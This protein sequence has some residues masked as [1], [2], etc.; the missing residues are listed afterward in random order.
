M[1]KTLLLIVLVISLTSFG[2][3]PTSSGLSGNNATSTSEGY[4]F[5]FSTASCFESSVI[6]NAGSSKKYGMTYNT[7]SSY[8]EFTFD[9]KI[10]ENYE[11]LWN[12]FPTRDCTPTT[13]DL[14][15]S[16]AK[17]KA[18][19]KATVYISNFHIGVV[20]NQDGQAALADELFSENLVELEPNKW[21]IVEFSI[22]TKGWHNGGFNDVDLDKTIGLFFTTRNN[23][24]SP[25]GSVAI[26]WITV[27]DGDGN[28]IYDDR[29]TTDTTL[30]CK[31][32]IYDTVKVMLSVTDTLRIKLNVVTGIDHKNTDSE[33]KVY[34]N[35]AVDKI[36]VAISNASVLNN[37]KLELRN[38]TSALLWEQTINTSDYSIDVS[39]LEGKGLYFLNIFKDNGQLIDVRK[40]ILE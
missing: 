28:Q 33:I 1:K 29:K 14:S 40:I 34:P 30:K 12:R 24:F 8:A 3:I 5:N 38:T 35:P 16:F 31:E 6:F 9:E 25:T 36:N 7:D 19:V 32:T 18:K 17:I 26:D 22:S 37:Y 4:V 2:Q 15:H 27:G 39:S 20:T 10:G 13:I 21:K 11:I 23:N